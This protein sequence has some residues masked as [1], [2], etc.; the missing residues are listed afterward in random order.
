MIRRKKNYAE[1]ENK[2]NNT[3][4][5]NRK[6]KRQKS[7]ENVKKQQIHKRT[8]NK[9]NDVNKF[10]NKKIEEEK[11]SSIKENEEYT[12]SEKIYNN[13]SIHQSHLSKYTFNDKIILNN[14]ST[15]L[16]NN[17]FFFDAENFEKVDEPVSPKES[18]IELLYIS[19][20]EEEAFR[21]ISQEINPLR[22]KLNEIN[23]F[24]DEKKKKLELISELIVEI[25]ENLEKYKKTRIGL[26]EANKDIKICF[27]S[28]EDIFKVFKKSEKIDDI[29]FK[30]VIYNS[31]IKLMKYI[32]GKSENL[33]DNNDM[34]INKL[35]NYD[36]AFIS[37]KAIIETNVKDIIDGFCDKNNDN[38]FYKSIK[39]IFNPSF[40]EALKKLNIGSNN[41]GSSFRG[42]NSY[43]MK[44]IYE[45]NAQ[46]KKDFD[47]LV[48][49][50][51]SLEK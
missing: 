10:N 50:M 9:S 17:S 33:V 27:Q 24:I 48:E 37:S 21:I 8:K 18:G 35:N 28:T 16:S 14:E 38:E 47:A 51:K 40:S 7:E 11:I 42:D 12:S 45:K 2:E 29:P 13:F 23:Y 41:Y 46:I 3:S 6:T 39:N 31:H 1:D 25:N 44:N 30:D 32:L 4:L 15:H 19:K 26:T 5:L 22:E 20:D 49:K 43:D 36:I 34:I